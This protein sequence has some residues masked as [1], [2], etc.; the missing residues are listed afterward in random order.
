MNT[1]LSSGY[2][3]SVPA[4]RPLLYRAYQL[5]ENPSLARLIA[6]AITS[7]SGR[8]PCSSIALH[9]PATAPG[10]AI[11]RYP[12]MFSFPTTPAQKKLPTEGSPLSSYM[13]AVADRGPR[14]G[15]PTTPP[16][17]PT[18]Y[19]RYP[20]PPM[21]LDAGSTTPMAKHA[22]TAASTALPPASSIRTPARVARRSFVAT[23]PLVE[24]ASR[25]LILISVGRVCV[26]GCSLLRFCRTGRR[27]VA[28]SDRVKRRIDVPAFGCRCYLNAA[29]RRR[30]MEPNV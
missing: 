19:T 22:A 29:L 23:M 25:L 27:I 9:R 6:G 12:S 28:C 18:W 3:N 21:P 26:T 24:K 2:L 4:R 15:K 8:R 10:V 16:A 30:P 5:G 1:R 14:I 17:S 11:E 20:P 7:A 13:S